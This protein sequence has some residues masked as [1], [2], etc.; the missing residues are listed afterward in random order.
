MEGVL[1][2]SVTGTEIARSMARILV[3]EYRADILADLMIGGLISMT[4]DGEQVPFA[5]WLPN[6]DRYLGHIQQLLEDVG[7]RWPDTV[8]EY[9]EWRLP[10]EKRF[11][12]V[13]ASIDQ[14][15]TVIVH[16]Q[17]AS[18][19]TENSEEVLAH[20]AIAG[21]VAVRLYLGEPI[22]EFLTALRSEP[23]LP[24]LLDSRVVEGR[25]VDAGERMIKEIWRRLGLTVLDHGDRTWGIKVGEPL[26]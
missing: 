19:G 14:T 5:Y 15:L 25:L 23:T 22:H 12:A 17:A 2:P 10:L 9:R 7:Q 26:R 21:L 13:A 24:S 3:A 16:A 20:P 1:L 8:Q 11:G 6:R 18:D 4:V